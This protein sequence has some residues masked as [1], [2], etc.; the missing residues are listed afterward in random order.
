MSRPRVYLAGAMEL[1]DESHSMEWRADASAYLSDLTSCE[2]VDPYHYEVSDS[3]HSVV[4]VDKSLIAK[5]DALLVDGRVPGWGT[6]M[7]V[8][9]AW[10]KNIPVVVWGIYQE[11]APK[12]LR[13][14]STLVVKELSAA[15]MEV[16]ALV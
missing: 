9:F 14:H 5:C 13:Y 6:A 2:A 4:N 8:Y 7:E 16:A 15:V 11:D 12:W 10:E 3:D 1:V